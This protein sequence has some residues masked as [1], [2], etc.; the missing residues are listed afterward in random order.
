MKALNTLFIRFKNKEK[1]RIKN[2][3]LWTALA[4]LICLAPAAKA[5]AIK[6][7]KLENILPTDT[8]IFTKCSGIAQLLEDGKTLELV[9]LIND[10]EV[11]AFI[12]NAKAQ[13]KEMLDQHKKEGKLPD[14]PFD[15]KEFWNLFDGEMAIA[16]NSRVT[17]SHF[18]PMP[19]VVLGVDMGDQNEAF[20]STV[21]D[22]INATASMGPHI[23]LQQQK[24]EYKGFEICS[25]GRPDM[26]ACICFTT[27]KNLFVATIN[28]FYLENII[29]C[30][31]DGQPAL[32]QE[33][34]FRKSIEKVGGDDVDLIAYLNIKPYLKALEIFCPYEL[35]DA[36][37]DLGFSGIDS[38]CLASTIENGSVRDSMFIHCP[39]E[40]KG[41]LKALTPRPISWKNVEQVPADA[42]SFVD[43]VFDPEII[44]KE[45]E[46]FIQKHIPEFYDAY[47]THKGF[48]KK[49][50]GIDVEKEL[51]G[52]MG[53]ELAVFVTMPMGELIPNIFLS[54][55]LD[56]A[57]GFTAF[58]NKVMSMLGNEFKI[59]ESVFDDVVMRHIALPF[60]EVPY[61]PTFI[62]K[63]N[64]LLISS[65]PMALKKYLRWLKSGEPGLADSEAFKG[66]AA[67]A[68]KNVS[69]LAFF[70]TNR[71]IE[72]AYTVG[73]PSIINYLGNAGDGLIDC[74][75]LPMTETLTKYIPNAVSY[76]VVDE[77]G[78]FKSSCMMTG[79][80]G[81]LAK[82]VL[83]ADYLIK[84]DLFYLLAMKA[85]E[86][87][88][89]RQGMMIRR[90][91]ADEYAAE[92]PVAVAAEEAPSATS[93][94]NQGAKYMSNGDHENAI[95][96]FS[97]CLKYEGSHTFKAL[98]NR[99]YCLLS[100]D[101][102]DEAIVDYTR[103]SK[104]ST[105]EYDLKY[106]HYNLACG[107]SR[108]NKKD[109]AM[110]HLKKSLEHGWDD[111]EAIR[112]D[113]DFNNIKEMEE[114]KAIVK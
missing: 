70:N 63:D 24:T 44:L 65:S 102:V 46:G 35:Y 40:K 28:R 32:S 22:L 111:Y 67:R 17:I 110:S 3:V 92:A 10:A 12:A 43:F 100:I 14:L 41:I 74:A 106:A 101:R 64:K 27:I 37:E 72:M 103:V 13:G 9:K 34:S 82:S 105:D 48:I 58:L 107:Y 23:A 89:G 1:G 21:Y 38:L 114:F 85:A 95:K 60:R 47:C 26:R 80:S 91:I 51:I 15:I 108:Y 50:S 109:I 29:D 25:V 30:Y 56:D 113:P 68:P 98:L 19:S 16:M 5:E 99:G 83:L 87:A 20:L 8:V 53:G 57:E 45:A 96:M 66:A 11:Q 88:G 73:Q 81:L 77:D 93:L 112:Y 52:P 84:E 78:I 42:L 18:G 97:A 31:V 6:H 59:T 2:V 4:L 49:G 36:I 39:G 90:E 55:D 104:E 69:S 75:M 71:L 94:F 61:T 54:L 86:E 7:L 62:I 33:A 76:S 79:V